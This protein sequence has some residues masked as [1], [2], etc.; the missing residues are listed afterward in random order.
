MTCAHRPDSW[1][2]RQRDKAPV[3]QE[4]SVGGEHVRVRVEVHQVA[5]GLDEED[6][7][8]LATGQHLSVGIGEKPSGDPAQFHSHSRCWV[9]IGRSNRGNVKY[10]LP[11]R[12]RRRTLS[13]THSPYRSTRFWCQLG[14]K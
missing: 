11:T 13:S 10:V 2:A 12:H 14:Q 1:H 5:E 7:P 3:G 8:R 9:K 6:Q 4:R